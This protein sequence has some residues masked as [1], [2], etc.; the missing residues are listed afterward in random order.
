MVVGKGFDGVI[1]ALTH[2]SYASSSTAMCALIKRWMD[3]THSFHLPFGEM[4]I[5]QLDF[6]AIIGLSFS[7]EPILMS[8][9]A[10]G[11]A[12]VRN[13]WLKDLFGATTAVKSGCILLV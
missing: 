5:T 10:Y 1:S 9:E 13:R 11:S 7:G 3:T 8:N 12:V 6:T 4:T 2:S